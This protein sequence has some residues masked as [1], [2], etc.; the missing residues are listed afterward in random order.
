MDNG[1]T[2]NTLEIIKNFGSRIKTFVLPDV[3]ISE[4]R[5][6]GAKKCQSYWIAFIDADVE[7]DDNWFVNLLKVLRDLESA[8]VNKN[9]IVTGSTYAIPPNSTWVERVWYRQLVSRDKS[10]NSYINS[11]N[12]IINR[13]LFETIGR[14]DPK[15][16]TGEDEKLCKDAKAR[17]AKIINDI[18]IRAVHNGYPKSLK[19]F[20]KR[21]RWLGLGMMLDFPRFWKSRALSLAIYYIFLSILYILLMFTRDRII[22]FSI[23][24]LIAFFIP[25]LTLACIRSIDY[26]RSIFSLTLLYFVY[27]WARVL[28]VFDYIKKYFFRK[29]LLG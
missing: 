14:F 13:K 6:Y 18:S 10:R 24:I 11:G 4:L 20:F 21:E 16:K 25:I 3:S 22:M 9:N 1:S 26:P 8:G 5:N 7:L 23:G 12:L 28:S 19:D 2:D 27:G 17:G 15:Y 29:H